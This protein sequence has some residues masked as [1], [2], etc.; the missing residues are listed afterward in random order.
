MVLVDY[1]GE[2]CTKVYESDKSIAGEKEM[3]FYLSFVKDKTMKVLEPMCGNGR[4]LIPFMEKGVD[5]EG[6]DI[7]EEMLKVCRQKAEQL[8]L[9]P[10]V[11]CEKIEDFKSEKKYDLILIPFGSFSLLSDELAE[12]GLDNLKT[13]L[14]DEGKILLTTVTRYNGIE[15]IPEWVETNRKQFDHETIVEYK[16]VHFDETNNLLKMQLKYESYQREKLEKTEIMDFP[17][18][19]YNPGEFEDRLKSKGFQNVVVHEVK[20]GYG[21]GSL[22]RVFECTK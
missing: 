5:I 6:F 12:R 22:F 9:M 2:L 19:L 3:E 13:V 10:T 21:K 16:K 1:Y 14:K 18:R 17:M 20:D 8:N 7:S 4:M 15:D 11:F